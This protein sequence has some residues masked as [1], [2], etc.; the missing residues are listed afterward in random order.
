M[1][2]PARTAL[3]CAISAALFDLPGLFPAALTG[4]ADWTEDVANK[5]ELLIQDNKLPLI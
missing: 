2:F 3:A 1:K 5:L 4:N